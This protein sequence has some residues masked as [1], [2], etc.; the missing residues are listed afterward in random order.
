[1]QLPEVGGR[2]PRRND[3]RTQR[4]AVWILSRMGWTI[5]GAVP[6][7]PRLI[8]IGAPHTS[9]WDG[10]IAMSVIQALQLRISVMGKDALFRIPLLNRF[11]RWLGIFPIDRS[12]PRGVVEQSIHRLQNEEQM[13]LGL[14][15][16]GTRKK[17]AKW[18]NGFYRIARETGLPIMMAALD[19]QRRELR[20][21]PLLYPSGDY[22]ADLEK[23]LDFFANAAPRRPEMLSEPLARKRSARGRV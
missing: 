12:C 4:L 1:M 2:V 15:P 11:I 13:W 5:V 8:A 14:A 10:I 16:E 18:K 17:A 9:N 20:L 7:E 22:P 6:N 3:P 21:A 23:I 19:Y